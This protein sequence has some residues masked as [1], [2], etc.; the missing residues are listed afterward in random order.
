MTYVLE[1]GM[2][3]GSRYVIADIY[4]FERKE[5]KAKISKIGGRRGATTGGL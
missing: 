2:N 1:L 4:A 3:C 5:Y